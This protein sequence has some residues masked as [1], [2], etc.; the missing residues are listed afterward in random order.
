MGRFNEL[1]KRLKV[2]ICVILLATKN[3]DKGRVNSPNKQTF[4]EKMFMKKIFWKTF[5]DYK[6]FM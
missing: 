3:V 2:K 5:R 1:L 4:Y 6:I